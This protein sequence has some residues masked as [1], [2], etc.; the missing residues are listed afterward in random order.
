MSLVSK[1]GHCSMK[2][3]FFSPK[4]YFPGIIYSAYL[5]IF[6]WQSITYDGNLLANLLL[7]VMATSR[8]ILK[9]HQLLVLSFYKIDNRSIKV[10]LSF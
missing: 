9:F 7:E 4:R 3:I 2:S 5:I 6:E 1:F 10:N 8:L